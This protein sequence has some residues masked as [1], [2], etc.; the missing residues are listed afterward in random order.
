MPLS[1]PRPHIIHVYSTRKKKIAQSLGGSRVA[2]NK[3]ILVT[4]D[5]SISPLVICERKEEEGKGEKNK[6]NK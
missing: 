6:K 2:A 3:G 5:P 4:E 1:L